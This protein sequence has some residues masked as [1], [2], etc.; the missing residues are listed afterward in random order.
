MLYYALLHG[1]PSS[2][3]PASSHGATSITGMRPS[4][5]SR[6]NSYAGNTD[7]LLRSEHEDTDTWPRED[8]IAIFY[9]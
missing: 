9:F 4:P 7:I 6:D 1:K 2:L 5:R 3:A 8:Q